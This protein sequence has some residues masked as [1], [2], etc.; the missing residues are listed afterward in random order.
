MEV[1]DKNRD[2]IVNSESGKS[3]IYQIE[4]NKIKRIGF[5]ENGEKINGNTVVFQHKENPL[6]LVLFD[7]E[8]QYFI[9]ATEVVED[10]EIKL[11]SKEKESNFSADEVKAKIEEVKGDKSKIIISG[12]SFGVGATAGYLIANHIG[13]NKWIGL[14]IGGLSLGIVGVMTSDKI[15][16]L[17]FKKD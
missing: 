1:V 4:D 2:Y 6:Y 15:K 3:P 12:V 17:V 9:P 13:F 8:K 10:K 14:A 11:E 7:K 16:S 5:L